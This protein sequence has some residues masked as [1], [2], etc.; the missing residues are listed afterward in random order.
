MEEFVR[1]VSCLFKDKGVVIMNKE[2]VREVIRDILGVTD[3]EITE[4]EQ[5]LG[6]MTNVSYFVTVRGQKFVVRLPGRGTEQLIDRSAEKASLIYGTELGINPELIYFDTESGVKITKKIE[7]AITL[8]PKLAR[9]GKMMKEIIALFQHLHHAGTPMKN[10]FELFTLIKH[11][12]SLVKKESPIMMEHVS[13]LKEDIVELEAVYRSIPK[14][15]VPCH[16][17]TVC[18]NIIIDEEKRFYLI[19]WEYSGMFDPMWDLATLFLSLQFTDEEERFFLKHYFEREPKLE[20]MQRVL[21]HKIFLDY[22]W[23]LWSFYKEAKGDNYGSRAFIRIDRAKEN[24]Q[25]FR[26][27]YGEDVVV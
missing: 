20:E 4:I 1:R 27:L 14:E 10:R 2:M 5:A 13:S 23:S 17:D 16:I 18:S 12:E 25:Q 8:T 19:D 26:K 15:E 24:I 9:E 6:G 11:Y 3:S 21:L 22:L 7:N